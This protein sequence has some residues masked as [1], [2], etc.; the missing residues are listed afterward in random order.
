MHGFGGGALPGATDTNGLLLTE[1]LSVALTSAPSSAVTVQLGAN[2]AFGNQQLFFALETSPGTFTVVQSLTFGTS[3]WDVAQT[4][5]V[6]GFDDALTEGFHKAVAT[7]TG[8][9][10]T[11]HFAVP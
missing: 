9:L 4:L 3:N 10:A 1:T 2:D 6:F 7:M 8:T 11:S 5:Y